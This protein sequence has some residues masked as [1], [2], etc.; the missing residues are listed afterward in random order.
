MDQLMILCHVAA[1]DK[2]IRYMQSF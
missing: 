2:L 1:N